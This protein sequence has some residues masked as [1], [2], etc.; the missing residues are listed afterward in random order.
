MCLHFNSADCFKGIALAYYHL[1][2]LPVFTFGRNIGGLGQEICDVIT[3]HD[4]YPV[5]SRLGIESQ[6]TI[7]FDDFI[8]HFKDAEVR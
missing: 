8:R 1:H 7:S 2:G 5:F 6:S 3:D 4:I